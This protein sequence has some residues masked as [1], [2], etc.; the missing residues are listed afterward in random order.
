MQIVDIDDDRTRDRIRLIA[1]V[2]GRVVGQNDVG[3]FT[4]RDEGRV[5]NLGARFTYFN[6][7]ELRVIEVDQGEF[8][9]I[10]LNETLGTIRLTADARGQLIRQVYQQNISGDPAHYRFAFR[11]R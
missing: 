5:V 3:V 6:T 1:V 8:G 11:V 7:F 9:K 10:G 4:A 2:D